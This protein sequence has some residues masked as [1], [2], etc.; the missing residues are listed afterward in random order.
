MAVA[1]VAEQG[2]DDQTQ[3]ERQADR[4]TDRLRQTET[5]RQTDRQTDSRRWRVEALTAGGMMVWG[6]RVGDGEQRDGE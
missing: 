3:T 1:C 2:T 6:K 5:D 4:Q